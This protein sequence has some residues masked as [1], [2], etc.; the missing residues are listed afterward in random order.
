MAGEIKL[1]KNESAVTQ[2]YVPKVPN[3][4][5]VGRY[6]EPTLLTA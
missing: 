5:I 6:G 2:I 4:V 1:Y 3:I